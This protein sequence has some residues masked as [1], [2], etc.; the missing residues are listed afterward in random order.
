MI[1]VKQIPISHVE[2]D[3]DETTLTAR[4]AQWMAPAYYAPDFSNEEL[5]TIKREA[6]DTHAKMLAF[7]DS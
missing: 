7:A 6:S 2:L 1:Q 5:E 3:M 4:S